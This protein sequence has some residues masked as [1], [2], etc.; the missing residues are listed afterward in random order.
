MPELTPDELTRWRQTQGTKPVPGNPDPVAGKCNADIKTQNKGLRDIGCET[1]R[2][3]GHGAGW[4]TTHKGFGHCKFHLGNTVNHV[5]GAAR[6]KFDKE[7]QSLSSRLKTAVAPGEPEVM[8]A[9][10]AGIAWEW[11]M[12]MIEQ[13]DTI[14]QSLTYDDRAGI[15]H[16]RALLEAMERASIQAFEIVKFMATHSLKERLVALEEHQARAVANIFLTVINDYRIE[17]SDDDRDFAKKQFAL[18]MEKAGAELA[19]SWASA[20]NIL[21]AIV[22]EETTP[23]EL[24]A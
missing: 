15:E 14:Q 2:Y 1:S 21:D 20:E 19:P 7:F 8:M 18:G 24:H 6:E 4:G 11:Y 23:L 17:L 22:V 10:M 5:R 13:M 12:F 16:T 9:K 3:C